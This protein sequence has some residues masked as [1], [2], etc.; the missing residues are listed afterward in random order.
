M[1]KLL[2]NDLNIKDENR[3]VNAT[4]KL[5]D[6]LETRYTFTTNV[7]PT[8]VCGIEENQTDSSVDLISCIRDEN[9]VNRLT[10]DN[11]GLKFPSGS[12]QLFSNAQ[13]LPLAT[14]YFQPIIPQN[15]AL[16]IKGFC[17]S[18]NNATVNNIDLVLSTPSR[19]V[20]VSTALGNYIIPALNSFAIYDQTIKMVTGDKLIIYSTVLANIG[21]V[22][23]WGFYQNV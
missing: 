5:T 6:E 11:C 21:H 23:Y 15:Q 2:N 18:N 16:Y 10:V 12:Q 3:L 19:G 17:F 8:M 7:I 1:E 4:S 20:G 14:N 22:Y 13:G 9:G